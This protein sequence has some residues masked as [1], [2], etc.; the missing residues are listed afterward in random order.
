MQQMW[1]EL[2]NGM[3]E[4]KSL[5]EGNQ[6]PCF[7][8]IMSTKATGRQAGVQQASS[9][10]PEWYDPSI[11]A[12]KLIVRTETMLAFSCK[13]QRRVIRRHFLSLKMLVGSC[14]LLQRDFTCDSP[15]DN[16]FCVLFVCFVLQHLKWCSKEKVYT[17][18]CPK[19]KVNSFPFIFQ[20][21]LPPLSVTFHYLKRKDVYIF[22][23]VLLLFLLSGSCAFKS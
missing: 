14:L 15:R 17:T 2:T 1:T 11:G 19:S 13:H 6:D 12:V 23:A 5:S 16:I 18:T 3:T 7:N 21:S 9:Q 10:R 22:I 20:C 4:A 8:D